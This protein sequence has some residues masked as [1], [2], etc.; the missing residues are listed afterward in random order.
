MNYVNFPKTTRGE[1]TLKKIAD[2]AEKLFSENGYYETEIH[3]I[4][5]QAGVAIGTF[6]IYFPDKRSVFLFLLESLGRNL[7]RTIKMKQLEHPHLSFIDMERISI[8]VFFSFVMEHSGLFRIVWQSQFVDINSF[9]DY[10]ER[11]SNG[12]IKQISAAKKAGEIRDFDPELFSYVLMGIHTFITLKYI[13]FDAAEDEP[14]EEI[15]E[16][17]IDFISYG[18]LKREQ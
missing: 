12:Y 14:D 7:R 18:M 15:I 4:T 1:R 17:L 5:N 8:R 11:F 6:Y 10:Y 13:A 9:R 3:D 2:A 16:Q